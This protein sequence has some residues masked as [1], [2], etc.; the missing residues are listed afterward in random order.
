MYFIQLVTKQFEEFKEEHTTT[1][2]SLGK[3]LKLTNP[4]ISIDYCIEST[5]LFTQDNYNKNKYLEI[6]NIFIDTILNSQNKILFYYN[7][8]P[9]E[10][11]LVAYFH[12]INS[13][14]TQQQLF[15]FFENIIQFK[16]P[17][18]FLKKSAFVADYELHS[19]ILSFIE[20]N[21]H[22]NK[23]IFNNILNK[24]IFKDVVVDLFNHYFKNGLLKDAENIIQK[25]PFILN[26]KKSFKFFNTINLDRIYASDYFKIG[27]LSQSKH[28][29]NTDYIS[30]ISN[31]LNKH[32]FNKNYEHFLF[33]QTLDKELQQS[34]YIIFKNTIY[35]KISFHKSVN[36]NELIF[37]MESYCVIYD[38]LSTEEKN[39]IIDYLKKSKLFLSI[40]KESN[41]L[42]RLFLFTT[43]YFNFVLIEFILSNNINYLKHIFYHFYLNMNQQQYD[44]FKEYMSIEDILNIINQSLID[45]YDSWSSLNS[46]GLSLTDKSFSTNMFT[47]DIY[48]ILSKI[49]QLDT[50]LLALFLNSN[51]IKKLFF[52]DDHFY[53][54]IF[55][56]Y[57]LKVEMEYF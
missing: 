6:K 45:S 22:L 24:F 48:N 35:K 39:F 51:N 47:Q 27:L 46:S 43:S 8:Y 57:N 41:K 26:S 31:S 40:I 53:K 34:L 14:I 11:I 25:F 55:E 15:S 44:H 10:I 20:K 7:Q 33:L 21:S 49:S 30:I 17:L 3:S 56:K 50:Q 4:L 1:F 32:L 37:L 54:Q 12:Y 9:T 2:F 19:F 29:H 5:F 23:S 18:L 16:N 13:N 52:I 28:I 36:K 42:N 38:L